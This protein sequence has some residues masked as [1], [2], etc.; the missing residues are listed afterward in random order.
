MRCHLK[1]KIEKKNGFCSTGWL[2]VVKQNVTFRIRNFATRKTYDFFFCG[3]DDNKMY[4]RAT[5]ILHAD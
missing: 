3:F 1:L 2:L 5:E 4:E